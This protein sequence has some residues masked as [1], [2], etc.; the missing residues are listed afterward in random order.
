MCFSAEASFIASAALA[1]AGGASVKVAKKEQ[2][3]IALIPLLFA[4]QQAIEGMQWL[5][6]YRGTRSL[7]LAY[8]FLFFG[9]ILWPVY[10]P[11][12]LLKVDEARR[13]ILKWFILAGAIVSALYFVG[14]LAYPLT[15]QVINKSID[16]QFT[17]PFAV[18]SSVLN[19]MTVF[20]ALII[21]SKPFFRWIGVVIAI[22]ALVTQIFFHF[23]LASV[24]CFFAA[25]TSALIFFYFWRE[26]RA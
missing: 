10:V 11:T 23:A 8:A 14:F 5:Y 12:A 16:Y 17:V 7:K 20:G 15:V 9:F 2:R 24:W 13:N 21:S 26:L 4:I 22:F 18:G 3:L 6:L 19:F 1:T 25:V